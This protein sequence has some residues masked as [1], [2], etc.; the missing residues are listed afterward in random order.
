M[1]LN[2]AQASLGSACP[3]WGVGATAKG[4]GD[5][6]ILH[7]EKQ[8]KWAEEEAGTGLPAMCALV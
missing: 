1:R 7:P 2:Q 4:V 6:P 5:L 3:M 8:L